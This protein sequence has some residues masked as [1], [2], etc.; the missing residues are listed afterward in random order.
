MQQATADGPDLV[1]CRLQGAPV[2]RL[3]NLVGIPVLIVAG[4]S[5]YHA[6]YDHCTAKYLEQAGVKNTYVRL[7]TV[8]IRGNGHMVMLEKNHLEIAGFI[9]KW[10]AANVR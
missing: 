4:E 8:G 10:I 9:E 2:R 7:D 1:R 5:S 6:M 3:P